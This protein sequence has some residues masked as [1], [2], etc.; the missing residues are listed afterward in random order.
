MPHWPK[1]DKCFEDEQVE[2]I[3]RKGKKSTRPWMHDKSMRQINYEEL[4]KVIVN[5]D[6][7]E[8]NPARNKEGGAIK[9]IG[10][11]HIVRQI[12]RVRRKDRSEYLITQGAIS[13]YDAFGNVV[14]RN[15]AQPEAWTRTIFNH[16]RIYN[17]KTNSTK[18]QTVGTLA[19][20]TV[21]EMPFSEKNLKELFELRENDS[22]IQ[23]SVKDEAHGNPV[24]VKKEA[25]IHETLKLF[26]KPFDYLFNA[27]YISPQQKAELR[28]QAID[29]GIIAPSTPLVPQT[30]APPKGTYG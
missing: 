18:M 8:Y 28:Q 15:C 16:Q 30:T 17:E 3:D 4:L 9:G 2:V 22:D 19:E 10:A 21:Y 23:F 5:P 24:E 20:E 27:E 29:A 13:G 1:E 14:R 7:N 26:L 11:K 12:I 6:T 25:N